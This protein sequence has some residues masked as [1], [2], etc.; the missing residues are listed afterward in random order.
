[1]PIIDKFGVF[2]TEEEQENRIAICDECHLK[3][4]RVGQRHCAECNCYIKFKV[5]LRAT[6]C[7]IEKWPLLERK[8]VG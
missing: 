6:T 7:P 3:T 4:M 8:V 2:S 1:M 5:K